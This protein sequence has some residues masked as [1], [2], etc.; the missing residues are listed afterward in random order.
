MSSADKENV[1]V[2]VCCQPKRRPVVVLI[3][4][5]RAAPPMG[6]LT[7]KVTEILSGPL[8]LNAFSLGGTLASSYALKTDVH[9][10]GT[11][12]LAFNRASA[13]QTLTGVSIDGSAGSAVQA[14]ARPHAGWTGF[15]ADQHGR[16]PAPSVPRSG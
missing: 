16:N 9:Y 1:A 10:I 12:S 7:R 6:W 15:A 3:Q 5:P 11:T 8:T 14:E 4:Q 2:G 13:A